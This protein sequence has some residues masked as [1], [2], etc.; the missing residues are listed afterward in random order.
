MEFI[1][2]SNRLALATL[3]TMAATGAVAQPMVYDCAPSSGAD[4][5]IIQSHILIAHDPDAGAFLVNDGVIMSV[6]GGPIKGVVAAESKEWVTFSWRIERIKLGSIRSNLDYRIKVHKPDGR[7]AF[8]VMAPSFSN[9]I[10]DVGHCTVKGAKASKKSG[11][12]S[13]KK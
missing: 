11:K 10:D 13:G 1:M 2:R 12:K 4:D 9:Q 3:L 6:Y 5:S 7:L 8:T